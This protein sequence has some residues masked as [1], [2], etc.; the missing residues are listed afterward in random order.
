MQRRMRTNDPLLP[1]FNQIMLRHSTL[2]PPYSYTLVS[3]KMPPNSRASESNAYLS[4]TARSSSSSCHFPRI[5]TLISQHRDNTPTTA[6][7]SSRDTAR[8][9]RQG[10]CRTRVR[11]LSCRPGSRSYYTD[12]GVSVITV[13][14]S[15]D[16]DRDL[17]LGERDAVLGRDAGAG[18]A[19]LGLVPLGALSR[20]VSIGGSE[21]GGELR[22]TCGR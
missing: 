3:H 15:R 16:S 8:P 22:P 1:R 20:D 17:Q 7:R 18:L 9:R 4:Q 12:P 21:M 19:A 2:E 11:G 10:R 5:K 13:T 14:G 6:R